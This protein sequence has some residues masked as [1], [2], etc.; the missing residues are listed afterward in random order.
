MHSK[1]AR[2]GLLG[3]FLGHQGH[4]GRRGLRKYPFDTI[5]QALMADGVQTAGVYPCDLDRAFAAL[6]RLK[7]DVAVWWTSGAQLEQLLTSGEVDMI[8]PGLARAVRSGGGR[9][10]RDRLESGHL[11]LRQ[12]GRSSPHA[13]RGRL[14]RIHQV[15]I[16]SQ[17]HGGADR[18]FSRRADI[19]DAFNL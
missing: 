13:Q 2:R 5:E 19:P 6:D 8:R 16:R 9:S 17:T 12:L 1:A 14:P 15:R 18:V 11:G 3:G 4:S 7:P 10:G